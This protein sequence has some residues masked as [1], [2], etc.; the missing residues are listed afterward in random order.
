[1]T[2]GIF[3]L[4]ALLLLGLTVASCGGGGGG[5]GFGGTD[6]L[7]VSFTTDKTTLQTNFVNQGPDIGGPFTNTLTVQ[8]KKNDRLFPSPLIKID[9]VSGLSSGA[10]FYLDGDPEHEECLAVAPQTCPPVAP[11]PLAFRN[12]TFEDTSGT[13]TSHFHASSI[14]GTVVLR[15]SAEDP[16]TNETIVADLTIKVGP[17]VSTGQPAL[18]DF[19][20][21]PSPLYITGQGRPD[22][23][24]FQVQV[25]DDA[26]QPVPNPT[27]NNLQLQLLPSRPNGGEKLVTVSFSGSTQEGNIV[28]TRTI[29]GIA[30]VA[31]HS[32]DKPGTVQIAAIADRADN[33]VDNG[34]QNSV[35]DVDTI[36]IGS[37]EITSLTFT[38][39]YPGAVA[40]RR[41]TLPLG[42]GDSIESAT[43]VYS[44]LISVIAVDEFGNP[45]PPGEFITFR[46]MDGP[47]TGYPDQGRGVFTIAGKDGNPQEGGNTFTTPPG[48]S[49]LAGA[50]TNCQLV[51]EGGFGQEG[52]WL[53]NGQAQPNLLAV[54]NTFNPVTDTE[55]TV[56]YTV[57]CPPYR[58]NVAN[59]VGD[60][61]VAA[62]ENG[63]ASTIMNYPITQL[64][65]CFK[66][67]A[68]ANGGRVGAVMGKEKVG[69]VLVGDGCTSW[70]LGI[71]TGAKLTVIPASD[72][73]LQVPVGQVA[74]PFT[75]DLRIQLLDGAAQ[76][77]AP[78][79]AEK[80][81]VQVVITDPDKDAVAVAQASVATATA[82]VAAAQSALSAAGC[83]ATAPTPP[84]TEP[85]ACEGLRSALTEAQ[86]ALA[87]ANSDLTLAQARDDLHTPTASFT[88]D[89]LV[90]G[91]DGIA[92]LTIEV[93]DLYTGASTGGKGDAKVEFFITTVGPE[94]LAETLT[95]TVSPQGAETEPA[96]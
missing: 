30:E 22:V 78:L 40:Q 93:S 74:P 34:I 18:T 15:A 20:I 13:V 38:G 10:L 26:G 55:F 94:I 54:F 91:V 61:T 90:T 73:K 51:L 80:L 82:A 67:S 39:P 5:G 35:T 77:P 79:P 69:S 7:K 66:L 16:D 65:R 52:S 56:P 64:G 14:P 1:M 71:P 75:K 8:V 27:G 36:P 88:P 57:G 70:Y 44:R 42:D 4:C 3:R 50:S 84:A 85:A 83:P 37:G 62:D 24:R 17:G 31:L 59:N 95:I 60:V 58:G 96:P 48:G 32:G 12:Q 63:L 33:N 45:P 2:G 89:P 25:L 21:V 68:E 46:L 47:M 23:K 49:S 11:T 92:V 87:K 6:T 53:V 41:N 72:Q 76:Q 29:N 43:G 9:V 81:S 86:T 28:N 19:L